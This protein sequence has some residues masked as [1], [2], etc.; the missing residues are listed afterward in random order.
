MQDDRYPADLA[1]GQLVSNQLEGAVV[2]RVSNGVNELLEAR[3]TDFDFIA[4]LLPF[5][6]TEEVI[7][8]F[9]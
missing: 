7:K 4:V 5:T 3:I 6:A 2:L 1:D 8:R 9:A